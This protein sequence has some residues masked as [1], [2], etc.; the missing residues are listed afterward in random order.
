M[1]YAGQAAGIS[2]GSL[3]QNDPFVSK[4]SLMASNVMK[5]MVPIPK[6]QRAAWLRHQL[7]SLWPRMGDEVLVSIAKIS[8]SKSRDQAIFDAIRL[9]LA[10]RLMEW[11]GD[12]AAKRGGISGLGDFASDARTFACTSASMGATV[13]GFVGAFRAG[14]DTSII[15]GATVGAGIANCNLETLQLQAQIAAAQANSAAI[16]AS[17]ASAGTARTVLYGGLAIVGILGLAIA[18]KVALK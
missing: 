12:Q 5:R 2:V 16:A 14:A 7:N 11:A 1:N 4:A 17:G 15:G 3:A 10:N 18:A 6:V 8:E 9:A 13:G